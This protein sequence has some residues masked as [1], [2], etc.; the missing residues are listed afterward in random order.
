ML[1]DVA[2]DG[3]GVADDA[4]TSFDFLQPVISKSVKVI[5]KKKE[6]TIPVALLVVVSEY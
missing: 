2:T 5:R 6:R 1:R 3:V 4:A